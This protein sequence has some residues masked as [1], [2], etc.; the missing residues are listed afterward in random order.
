L[1]RRVELILLILSDFIFINVAWTLYYYLRVETGWIILANAPEYL[2]PMFVVYLYWILIFSVL[3]L[4]QHWFVRSRFDEF[5][6]VLKAIS[7]GCIVLFFAIFIDD[8]LKNATVIS[9]FLIVVYWALLV[10]WVSLGRVLIRGFQRNLLSKGIGL[11]NCVIVGSGKKAHDLKSQLDNFKQLG[12]TFKGFITP[13]PDRTTDLPEVISMQDSLEY[14]AQHNATDILIALE[15][16]DKVKLIE[17]LNFYSKVDVEIKIMPDMYEIISGMAKTS[18]IYGVHLISVTP[19]LMPISSRIIKRIIDVSLSTFL[20]IITS[21]ILLISGLIIK[22]TSPGPVFYFQERV[23]RNGKIFMIFK[24]RTMYHDPTYSLDTY[25]TEK[26]DPR[27]TKIGRFLRKTRID[28]IPQFINVIKNDMS[29]VGPRPEQ[30]KI[31]KF[32][33]KEIPYYN[34]RLNIKPGITG[35]AQVKH[36]YD[37]SLEDVKT[38]LQYEFYYIENMSLSLDFKIIINTIFVI[39]SLK[40]R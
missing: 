23:G 25:W 18:Q 39:L 20:L 3:G 21:P 24:L 12:Y 40:G 15:P 1:N 6:S 13:F 10:F 14:I 16:E 22:F 2:V 32:L 11:K 19:E 38:K 4:Y 9:R 33:L 31:I 5:S 34:K 29:I 37:E 7:L 28:E 17:I 8:F 30:P 36:H 26:N 27:I 35:W